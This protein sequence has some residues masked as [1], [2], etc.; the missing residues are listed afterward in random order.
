M[1]EKG[2]VPYFNNNAFRYISDIGSLSAINSID[3]T[4]YVVNYLAVDKA[5]HKSADEIG[6]SHRE[7]IHHLLEKLVENTAAFIEKHG[8][9]ESIRIHVVSDHG[10]TRIPA[11]VQ[12]DL[13]PAFFK[14]NDFEA[15]S[16]RYVTVS[17]E[18]F[19]G[20]ADNLKLDCFFLPA[21]DFLNPENVLCARRGNRFLPTDKDFY[22]HGGLLPEEIV[23]PCMVFEPAIVSVQD[24]TILLKKNEF[25]FRIESAELE[26]GNPN[27]TAVEHIQVSVMNGNVESEPVRVAL[28]NGKT[29]TVVQIK[30]RF[31]L[32]S[33]P[34]EQTNLHIRVRFLARGEQHTFDVLP[35]ITMK[36]MVEENSTSVFDD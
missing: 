6:M 29:N 33:L 22:V 2:W 34:A 20:L 32:T 11:A 7:H 36:K 28:L 24:L 31:K 5:L 14:S 17:N 25:R 13:D 3:A 21:N 8:L 27:D 30:A 15:H 9:Q 18:R 19:A 4:T 23:V 26:I 12:N 1:I 10:S 35:K 16:H